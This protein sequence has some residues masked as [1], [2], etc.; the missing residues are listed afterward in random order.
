[1][2]DRIQLIV[3]CEHASQG[4]PAP[5]R[6]LFAGH[7]DLLASHRGHDAGSLALARRLAGI[8]DAPLFAGRWTR[9]LVDLNRSVGH[10]RLFSEITRALP[11]KEQLG[12]IEKYYRP[13]RAKVE[14]AVA[15]TIHHARVLHISVHSFT[16]TMN[17]EVRNADIGLLYDPA[18]PAER[19]LAQHWK[20]HL[21]S[22]LVLRVRC[23]YPYRG[24]ADGFTTYLRKQFPDPA[25]AGIE[26]EL[27]Q[28]LAPVPRHI[29][30]R[31]AEALANSMHLADS[32]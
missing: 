19:R 13:Y 21:V 14:Q 28:A 10:P 27:N 30:A 6:G 8:L 7:Q 23:N 1:M 22:E 26:L 11:H 4:V 18:R 2:P 31:I 25:Y 15:R 9:L 24:T 12:I 3:T 16:P 20:R 17:N 5:C 29:A 32:R